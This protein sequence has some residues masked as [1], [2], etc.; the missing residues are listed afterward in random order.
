MTFTVSF[1][2]AVNV[3]GSPLLA[4]NDGGNASFASGSGTSALT[5]TYTVAANQNTP[6]LTVSSLSPNGGTIQD[7]ASNNANLSGA[8]NYHPAGTLQIDTTAPV[9][10]IANTGG[11]I[12]QATQIV[13]DTVD[14]AD[15]GTTVTVLDGTTQVGTTTVPASGTW[16]SNVTLTSGA[17]T[18]TAQDTDA[19]GNTGTSNAVTYTLNST[20]PVVSSITTSGTGIS[21]GTGDL[22]AGK[23]VTFTVNFSEAVNVTG[24]PLLA[25]NDGGNASYASGSGT[26]ALT[27]TY[28]VAANQNTPDLT[29]SSLSLN[30][31]T[32]QDAALNNADL[33]GANNYH[34]PGT[35]QIDTTAPVVTITNTGGTVTQAT[36][37]VTDTV[38]TADTGTTV[39]VLDGTTQVGTTTVPASGTWT[40]NVTLASGANTLTAQDTDAAGNTGTSNAVT[41]TLNST[42]PV[43]SSI[44]ASGT[45]I[46]NGTGDLNAGKIVTFTVNFSEAVNVTGSPLLAL[47]DGGNASY[48]SGSGTSALT[49]TYTVAANQNTPDL[50]VSSLSLN[51]GTIQDAA[52][53]N[54]NLSGANNYHPPGVL[55]IDTTAPVVTIANTGGMVTQATQ[56]VTGTVD[57]ADTGTTVTVLDGTTQVGTTT[58]PASGTWTSNVTLT[59]G[60]NTLTAQD[61]DAAGNTGTSNAVTYT[62]NS[63]VPVVSSI[64]A[65]GTGISNGT[66]D[67][68]AGKIVTFT[69]SFSA[70]VNVTGSPLLALNDGGNASYASGSG[71]SALTFTYTVAANQNTPDL[72]VS[73]LSLN[74]GTI[75]DAALNNANLSGANNYQPP[76]TLQIDTTA[77]VVTIANTGGTVTQATQIVTG[78]VDTADAGTTVTV[79]DGTT[80]VGTTTVPASG[81]WTSNVTLTSGANTLTAQDTDAA[82]NTGTSN[83]V[84][85]TLASPPP[86]PPAGST[87]SSKHRRVRWF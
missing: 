36:Q 75:Q 87:I 8:N 12:T 47:N 60:A 10:T 15:A 64:T 50:T 27:F 68:N 78:T 74:G 85:Y 2:A 40:S 82:G 45:G 31:G 35:L 38:D 17:N 57:A 25:L 79:L 4:L 26:S 19:A 33:S 3:T 59:S 9:V 72:T 20:V 29:V 18:L 48:A 6:D 61:T 66:G 7:A 39:T 81:T 46:S 58:V 28:T 49:F 76:G 53:N 23:I 16:T 11:L 56:I 32:I 21:N 22:N 71:T 54:A 63:T 30:G 43:V 14:A 51:G 13:T 62:L 80:Q 65:S 37:I 86:P 24:S 84:T 67:L 52:L 77:P 55:Q 42:V 70:A 5:F 41:Y 34:P 69:V 1:S 44:T 73:S 83:A